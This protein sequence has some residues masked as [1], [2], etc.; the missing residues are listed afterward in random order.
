MSTPCFLGLDIGTLGIK[1][2]VVTAAGRV[3]ATARHDHSVSHPAPGW[4][5]QD[6]DDQWWGDGLRVIRDLLATPDVDP[7]E[8]AA[9]GVSGLVPCLCLVDAAGRLLRP[10]ILYSDNRAL[11]QLAQVNAALASQ[12]TAQ[13]VTPKLKWLSEHEPDV[14]CAAWRVLS[15]HNYVVY[16]LTGIPSMDYD[17]ASIMGGVFDAER[18]AWDAAACRQIGVDIGLFPPLHPVTEVVGTISHDAAEVT[19]LPAGTPVIAGTGDTFP[20]LVGCGAVAEGD[21]M[22]SLGTTGLLTLSTRGLATAAAG[23]HFAGAG[24][25]EGAVLWAA[26]VLACGRLLAWF[27]E[28]LGPAVKAPRGEAADGGAVHRGLPTYVELDRAAARL[29]PGSEGLIALPHLMGRRTPSPDPTARGMLWG[30]TPSHTAAH[31]YRALLESVAFALR[32]GFDPI[33]DRVRRIV[34]TA[35]GAASPLWRQ[36][37]ADVLEAPVEHHPDASGALG[38][39]FLTGFATGGVRSFDE[40]SRVWL[41]QPQLTF[42]EP[43]ASTVYAEG[44]EAYCRL[45]DASIQPVRAAVSQAALS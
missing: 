27:R 21:A 30:L 23:P 3:L 40:I 17:T 18:K 41:A 2:V 4:A 9:I 7:A 36:I 42:P 13:A 31:I 1:G 8:I 20:T 5:E 16:R 24:A 29:A 43:A 11:A 33:R 44:Y 38:I 28:E 45:D 6:A 39:A 25:D 26:N 19:G 15:S 32:R 37:I 35:G 14:M 22:I 12:L 10:A 34:V